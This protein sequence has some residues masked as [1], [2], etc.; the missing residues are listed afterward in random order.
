[1]CGIFGILAKNHS[2]VNTLKK[3]TN[4]LFQLS[5]SRGSEAAGVAI[6]FYKQ[7][8]LL[9]QPNK[10]TILTKSIAYRQIWS[11]IPNNYPITIIGHS[12][13]ATNGQQFDNHN[14][15]PVSGTTSLIVHNGI[16]LND[17]NLW[18]KYRNLQQQFAVDSEIIVSLYDFYRKKYSPELAV[19]KIFEEI[20]GE[21]S[22]AILETKMPYLVLATNTGSLYYARNEGMFMF[23]SE[24]FILGQIII[25]KEQIQQIKAGD[26]LI[27]NTHQHYPRPIID[28]SIY[29]SFNHTCDLFRN[30]IITLEKHVP[31]YTA[32]SKIP[33]CTKCIMP[34]TMPLIEFD[35]D[36]V[37]NFCRTYKPQ[38]PYGKHI[39]ESFVNQYRSP[40]GEADC[41]VALSGGRD[42]SYGLK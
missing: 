30:R 33:R 3:I 22:I 27:I 37:C 32:I 36:G 6:S 28:R 23:A 21:A 10:G 17:H 34:I 18:R 2:N 35:E 41:I 14:N 11:D 13:L 38:H 12:R 20:Q 1:M 39:L 4:N 29:P 24:K 16:I 25:Q 8:Y 5:E 9:K 40:N 7:T 15:Q 31:D 42:S 19:K 26:N